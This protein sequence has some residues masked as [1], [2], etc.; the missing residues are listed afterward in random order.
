MDGNKHRSPSVYLADSISQRYIRI[1]IQLLPEYRAYILIDI[2][3]HVPRL[4]TFAIAYVLFTFSSQRALVPVFITYFDCIV[5]TGSR[6]EHNKAPIYLSLANST[7]RSA[8]SDIRTDGRTL[9]TK[10]GEPCLIMKRFRVSRRRARRGERRTANFALAS[11]VTRRRRTAAE[12]PRESPRTIKPFCRK[13]SRYNAPVRLYLPFLLSPSSLFFLFL[14]QR[15]SLVG[16]CLPC[17]RFSFRAQFFPLARF[18]LR[19]SYVY[20]EA[21]CS[22]RARRKRLLRLCTMNG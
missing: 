11:G 8:Q 10:A 18:H 20:S 22:H 13:K 3:L 5:L 6:P 1:R 12:R 17:R 16:S 7:A 19:F 9:T 4:Y 2:C 15:L 14:R 21:I